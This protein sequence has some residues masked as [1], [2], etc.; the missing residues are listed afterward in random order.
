MLIAG[1]AGASP[2]RAGPLASDAG[3]FRD[4][5]RTLR[6]VIDGAARLWRGKVGLTELIRTGRTTVL[7]GKSGMGGH[8]S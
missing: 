7:R 6:K 3:D 4:I 8:G 1:S 2:S 5:L